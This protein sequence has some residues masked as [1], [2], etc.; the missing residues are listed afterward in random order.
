MS[1]VRL[2]PVETTEKGL[3]RR[4]VGTSKEDLGRVLLHGSMMPVDSSV[5]IEM[6]VPSD[7]EVCSYQATFKDRYPTPEDAL[8]IVEDETQAQA[9]FVLALTGFKAGI[10][11]IDDTILTKLK[12]I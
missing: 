4:A 12:D 5:V 11:G 1:P 9:E 10:N 2:G 7:T 3:Q 6:I 8:E